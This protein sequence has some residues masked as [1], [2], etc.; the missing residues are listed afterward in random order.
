MNAK[1]LIKAA[2][3]LLLAVVTTVGAQAQEARKP[4]SPH[5]HTAGKV[6]KADVL[7]TYASPFVKGRKIFGGLEAYGKVWRAGA[8]SATAFTTSKDLVIGGKT[9]PAGKYA[10]FAIPGETEWTV[11]F[12]SDWN[13]WGAYK[14]DE[15]KD[16]LRATVKPKKIDLAES[17]VYVLNKDGFSLKWEN[18]EV[19]VTFKVK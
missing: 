17:L 14:Y 10:F 8:D 15:S 19:P 3:M 16:V 4:K 2:L 13:Q 11:I 9:L 12:N 7:I 1:N 5:T 18:V 6:G